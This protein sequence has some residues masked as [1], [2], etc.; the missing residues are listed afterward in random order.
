MRARPS[1]R[2]PC[3][4]PRRERPRPPDSRAACHVV[5]GLAQAAAL[6]S[7]VVDIAAAPLELLFFSSP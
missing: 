3:R 5:N 2:L 6:I 1:P 7:A 4:L